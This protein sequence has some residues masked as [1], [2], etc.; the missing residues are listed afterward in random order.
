MSFSASK[1]QGRAGSLGSNPSPVRFGPD[2]A[3]QKDLFEAIGSGCEWFPSSGSSGE[4]GKTRLLRGPTI[5]YLRLLIRL[6]AAEFVDLTVTQTIFV[7]RLL[8]FSK[9]RTRRDPYPPPLYSV[10]H[11]E[12]HSQ[13]R[14]GLRICHP[15]SNRY[16]QR[17]PMLLSRALAFQSHMRSRM[18]DPGRGQPS[19]PI[20]L[21]EKV[22][23][24]VLFLDLDGSCI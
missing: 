14:S 10:F 17:H 1:R 21:Y 5:R 7:Y 15:A 19:Q 8:V 3:V 18:S 4:L 24:N 13:P 22:D 9:F 11:D 12:V 23:T 16:F 6:S 2:H 20:V